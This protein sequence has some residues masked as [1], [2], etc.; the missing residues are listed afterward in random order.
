MYDTALD[1]IT[2][3]QKSMRT[4][5]QSPNALFED[6]AVYAEYIVARYPYRTRGLAQLEH[7]RTSCA[8][9]R[10]SMVEYTDTRQVSLLVNTRHAGLID[11]H[12]K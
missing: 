11:M 8:T 3:L 6:K 5:G 9:I 7:Q 2:V 1:S 10:Y 4:S 12:R